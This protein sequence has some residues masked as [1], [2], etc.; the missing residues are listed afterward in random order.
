[1]EKDISTRKVRVYSAILTVFSLLLIAIIPSLFVHKVTYVPPIT[2][3]DTGG[4]VIVPV[5]HHTMPKPPSVTTVKTV[6]RFTGHNAVPKP[7]TLIE[8]EKVENNGRQSDLPPDIQGVENNTI[9]TTDFGEMSNPHL[10]NKVIPEYPNIATIMAQEGTVKVLCTVGTDGNVSNVRLFKS[11]GYAALDKAAMNAAKLCK[12]I[13][14]IQNDIP[15]AL[16]ITLTFK[17]ELSG[18]IQLTNE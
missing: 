5:H 10:I 3:I 9:S 16:D 18:D 12:F 14:A 7:T 17:F 4:I 11:S 2:T 8:P 15:I 13:P 6:K 1:M